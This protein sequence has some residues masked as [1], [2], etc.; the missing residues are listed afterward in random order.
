MTINELERSLRLILSLDYLSLYVGEKES[1]LYVDWK[2][3][4]TREELHAGF[5]LLVGQLMAYNVKFWLA[6]FTQI[7]NMDT[8]DQHWYAEQLVAELR[9]TPLQKVARV[10]SGDF[11]AYQTAERLTDLANQNPLIKGQIKHQVFMSIDA[12]LSWFGLPAQAP[13][14]V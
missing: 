5:D 13:A 8:E 14:S 11:D 6:N 10:V 4:P 9:F 12:A 1:L 7:H 3:Q 2:R